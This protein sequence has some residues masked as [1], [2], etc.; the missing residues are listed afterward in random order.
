MGAE[1]PHDQSGGLE[2]GKKEGNAPKRPP[3][4]MYIGKC[5]CFLDELEPAKGF[6][7]L[8]FLDFS[9]PVHCGL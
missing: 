6:F 4:Y 2:R 3:I 8:G 5:G 9:C 1:N 7:R